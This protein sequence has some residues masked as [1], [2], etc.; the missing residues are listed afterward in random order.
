VHVVG[1]VGDDLRPGLGG[2]PLVAGQGKRAA[3]VSVARVGAA[4]DLGAVPAGHDRPAAAGSGRLDEVVVEPAGRGQAGLAAGFTLDLRSF[5][6]AGA[7][8]V[9]FG[10]GSRRVNHTVLDD[11]S[12]DGTGRLGGH[13]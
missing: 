4:E 8:L 6:A 3:R 1:R 2:R 11:H 12:V 7:V 5:P 10:R 13:L 9:P